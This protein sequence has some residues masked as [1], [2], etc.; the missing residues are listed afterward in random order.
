[1]EKINIALIEDEPAIADAV[2]YA[3]E[4]EGYAVQ[5]INTGLAGIEYLKADAADLIILDIG[6]PDINGFEFFRRLRE[7]SQ[8]PV[9]FLTARNVEIDKVAGLE[10]GADDYVVKPFSPRELTARV[11]AVLRRVKTATAFDTIS[12]P[13]S[14]A[15][16]FSIDEASWIVWFH[17]V[18]LELTRHEF[19]ILS[20]LVRN[21]K[22]IYTREKLL[23]LVWDAPEH[24]LDRTVDAHIKN[25]R[26]KL[27][28]IDS[29][30]DPIK[31]KRGVGYY[32]SW[33][34]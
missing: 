21:P 11:A 9:I 19:Q 3:L 34:K 29:E 4:S 24:R 12:S 18:E 14:T 10:M 15:S 26:A 28:A 16:P 8:L 5:W 20:I 13:K 17:K 31:T 2:V 32:A 22:Q 6:L 7:F 30:S 27:R 25:I 1:M 33:I 23:A